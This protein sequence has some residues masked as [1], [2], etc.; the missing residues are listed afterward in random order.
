MNMEQA[1]KCD[2]IAGDN[3]HVYCFSWYVPTTL[4]TRK[5]ILVLDTSDSCWNVV[6]NNF[7]DLVKEVVDSLKRDDQIELWQMGKQEPLLI[8]QKKSDSSLDTNQLIND[9]TSQIKMFRG[10][11]WLKDTIDTIDKQQEMENSYLIVITDGKIFDQEETP[12][13]KVIDKQ[14]MVIYTDSLPQDTKLWKLMNGIQRTTLN[15]T[16][17]KNFLS[18]PSVTMSLN[19]KLAP[20]TKIYQIK[21]DAPN[22]LEELEGNSLIL[23]HGQKI[24]LCFVTNKGA[25]EPKLIFNI[26]NNKHVVSIVVSTEPRHFE[27]QKRLS[28]ICEHI[29]WKYPTWN[30]ELLTKIAQMVSGKNNDIHAKILCLNTHELSLLDVVNSQKIYC[31]GCQTLLILSKSVSQKI[32]KTNRIFLFPL[33]NNN[34][35]DGLPEECNSLENKYK[36]YSIFEVD[37]KKYLVVRFDNQ[38]RKFI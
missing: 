28:S 36:T 10:G 4:V 23:S 35:V 7:S 33:S 22:P 5:V 15:S 30:K 19:F 29:R 21:T 17:I 9:L 16:N 34:D 6:K 27:L 31:D 26:F 25:A 20:D 8:S 14:I 13:P 18:V 1:K 12:L 32:I 37:N 38:K 24:N 11:T 3:K 2:C